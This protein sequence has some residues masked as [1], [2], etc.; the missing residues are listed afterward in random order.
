MAQKMLSTQAYKGTRDFYPEQMRVQQW[1]FSQMRQVAEKFGYQEYDGPLLESFDLYAAKTGE[2]IVSQQLYWFMDRGE[3]KVAIRPEMTPT[4]ARMVAAKLKELPRPIRLFSIPNLWRYER[5]Q[6]G[7]L[8]E[9]WQ[10][11]IDVLG[12]DRVLADAEILESAF[13]LMK[14]LGGQDFVEISVNNRMLVEHVFC[15]KLKFSADTA[16]KVTKALDARSKIGEEKFQQ[17]LSDLQISK[18]SQKQME[19]FFS[20]D[21]ETVLKKW[22]C[23]GAQELKSLFETV[24]SDLKKVIRFDP[25]VLRGMDYYTGTVFEMYDKSPDNNRAMF[26]GGR[27]DNLIGLFSK[28]QLSGV[29]FGM[30]DVTMRDFLITHQL[31]PKFEYPIDVY[32]SLPSLGE[33]KKMNEVASDLREKGYKVATALS[34]GSFKS[35]LKEANKLECRFAVLFGEQEL[36]EGK[37]VLK[38]LKTGEQSTPLIKDLH[39]EIKKGATK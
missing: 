10:F 22:D 39:T 31:L 35:Q 2:E 32:V 24:N 36:K 29:G 20:S 23:R 33:L 15:E 30:G 18:E 7:R 8:R 26:G 28:E 4:L 37:A 19:E 5:P 13:A 25:H 34:E 17:W 9:H 27:Y 21:F 38:D 12:G 3:R 16:L 11:N 1:M 6:K 14:S